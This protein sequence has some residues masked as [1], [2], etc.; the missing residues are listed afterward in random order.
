MTMDP[1]QIINQHES[2]VRS[3]VRGFPTTFERASGS[4]MYNTNGEAYLDFFAG[5]SVMNYGHN[6][7]EL[8]RALI[9]YLTSDNITHSLDMASV[10]RAMAPSKPSR[11]R[12]R[13]PTGP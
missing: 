1:M 2:E 7:P 3:Y 4:Y 8:K 5:A 10:A 6:H 13:R 9:D 11:R 12:W